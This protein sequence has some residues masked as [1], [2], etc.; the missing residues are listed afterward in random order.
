MSSTKE[1]LREVVEASNRRSFL[2]KASLAGMAG[3]VAPAL[4][5]LFTPTKAQATPTPSA[6]LDPAILNFAL[7]LEY[8]EAEFYLL[9]TT[10]QG[11]SANGGTTATM[12]GSVE[13]GSVVVKSNPQ[14]PFSNDVVKAY[15]TEIAQDEL[16]HVTFLQTAL[17][18][19]YVAAPN[20]ILRTASSR[21]ASW[22][23]RSTRW[24]TSRP[25]SIRLPTT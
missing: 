10:G 24:R 6:E 19:A 13:G 2:R 15:A 4:V 18:A 3:A 21:W 14:V 8:L 16:N 5:P 23:R 7:N 11:I 12:D 1:I 20:L 22:R 9:A 25:S 17:G